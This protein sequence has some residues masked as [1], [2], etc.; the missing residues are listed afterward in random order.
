[1][2]LYRKFEQKLEAGAESSGPIRGQLG[3]GR[4]GMIWLAANLVVTTLL[5][6]T[7]FVPGLNFSL[8]LVMIVVGTLIGAVILVL[9]GNIGTRTGLPTMAITR[10]AF[11]ARGSLLP[12]AANVIVLMGWSWVQAMLAGVTVNYLVDSLTGFSN[13][14]LFSVICQVFVVTLALFGHEGISKVEPWLAVLILAIMAYVFAMAFGKYNPEEFAAIPVDASLGYTPFIVLDIVIATAISWTV[15]SADI[16]RMARNTRASIVGSG[17][18][19]TLSTVLAMILGATAI[20]YVILSGGQ[21][22]EFDPTILVAAFGAPLAIAIFLSVMAT[23]TMAVYGMITSVVNSRPERKLPF[24]ATALVV[25]A[26]S[27]L[28]ATWLALLDQFTDF[29]TLIGA[30]FVPVF[31]IMIVDYYLLKRSRYTRDILRHSGGA[32]W[33]RNGVNPIAVGVWV[34]GAVVAYLLTYMFP[35]P[36]GATVPCFFVSFLLYLALSRKNRDQGHTA[37]SE[38]LVREE[39]Q[40]VS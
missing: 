18:G 20:G 13:P 1:M 37:P 9:V 39:S 21:A 19:Y 10:G 15:L 16:N 2:N 22:T 38:H 8:A 31:A 33:Y 17:I 14:V 7:F 6:G 27:I 40:N 12:V 35:S 36:I 3:T 30:F 5:T 34:A 29:L 23:N 11:G 25:G 28:G 4:I 26:V 24:L 32:Y